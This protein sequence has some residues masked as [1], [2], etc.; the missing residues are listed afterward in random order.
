[1]SKPKLIRITTVPVSLIKLISGQ[2]KFMSENL[3]EVYMISS[4][5]TN[6]AILESKENASYIEVNMTRTISPIKDIWALL[7][8]IFVLKKLKP[9]IVHTHTPKAGLIG[10]LAARIAGVPLRLHTVAG[11]P[12]MEAVGIKRRVLNF[13]EGITYRCA[14]M[15]YPNSKGLYDFIIQ[16][17][18]TSP[19]KLKIIGNGSSNGIDTAYFNINSISN[20]KI[21]ELKALHDIREDDFVFIFVGRIVGDKGVNE[22]IS[23]FNDITENSHIDRRIKLLLV[24][25]FESNL[26]PLDKVSI[27]IIS[28]NKCIIHY[29]WQDDV[30]PFFAISNVLVFPSYREGFPNVVMQAGAMGL[31][32]IVSDI[33]GCNE[34]IIPHKNGLIVPPKSVKQLKIAML[35]ISENQGDYVFMKENAR[36]LIVSRYEQ[37]V[38]WKNLLDEYKRL[39]K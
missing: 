22:L 37:Q 5:L 15:I 36:Q 32:S 28:K 38:I 6:K 8:M 13:V 35:Q 26:G 39:L 34:I 3:F 14:T 33:N 16:Q 27:D 11:L 31:P 1:M 24:G 10:M 25:P 29:D 4:H 23:A 7:N 18:F 20:A 17:R 2:M 21:L 12:L 19:E 9:T 30:R